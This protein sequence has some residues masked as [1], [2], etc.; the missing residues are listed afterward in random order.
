MIKI[1]NKYLMHTK[2]H[3]C[4]VSFLQYFFFIKKLI[5]DI[6]FIVINKYE[7]I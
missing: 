2:K 5:I 6:I 1:K 7:F 3:A 4:Y